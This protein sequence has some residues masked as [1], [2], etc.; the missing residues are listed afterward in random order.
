[1]VLPIMMRITKSEYG[2]E[3]TTTVIAVSA[4]SAAAIGA[5]MYMG[6]VL[7][8]KEVLIMYGTCL[9]AALLCC[10][11]SVSIGSDFGMVAFAGIFVLIPATALSM[12]LQYICKDK[13][14]RVAAAGV[15]AVIVFAAQLCIISF[16]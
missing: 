5:L 12:L 4:A 6:V 1:M 3:H 16:G 8:K 9:G 10:V 14:L 15:G 7:A 2:F 13:G 11:I